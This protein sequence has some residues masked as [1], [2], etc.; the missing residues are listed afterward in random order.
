ML[1]ATQFWF[2]AAQEPCDVFGEV[3]V[4]FFNPR[5]LAEETGRSSHSPEVT[6]PEMC[7][8][9]MRVRGGPEP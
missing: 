7:D 2:T 9:D 3:H 6:E 8:R 4:V 1:K 5:L